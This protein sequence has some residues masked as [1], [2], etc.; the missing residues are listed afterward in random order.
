[1]NH[2]KT[3]KQ[4]QALFEE[5]N[6]AVKGNWIAPETGEIVKILEDAAIEQQ[7]S[8]RLDW[9]ID[10]LGY[11]DNIDDMPVRDWI[12]NQDARAAID[13]AIRDQRTANTTV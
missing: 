9:L 7:D 13:E 6:K 8:N 10:W 3:A 2:D 4:L 1:M 5:A 11:N 12:D